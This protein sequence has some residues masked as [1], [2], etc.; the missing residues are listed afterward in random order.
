M[1]SAH[2]QRTAGKRTGNRTCARPRL[3]YQ[4]DTATWLSEPAGRGPVLSTGRSRAFLKT[5]LPAAAT[6]VKRGGEGHQL[7]G[8][9]HEPSAQYNHVGSRSLRPP[10]VPWRLEVEGPGGEMKDE[11]LHVLEVGEEEDAAMSRVELVEDRGS[12]RQSHWTRP[13]PTR[14]SASPGRDLWP[15]PSRSAT[16]RKKCLV[17]IPDRMR[18]YRSPM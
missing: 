12:G 17:Q 6:I 15:L 7:W 2:P 4:G 3:R 16:G 18:R 13:E 5:L 11:F 14:S 10:I 8:H 1:V 9:P